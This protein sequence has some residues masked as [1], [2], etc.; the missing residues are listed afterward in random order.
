MLLPNVTRLYLATGPIDGR[1]SFN[2]LGALVQSTLKADPL[3]GHF[4][5]FYNK[6]RNLVKALYWHTN[7]FCLWQKR[8]EKGHFLIPKD[9]EVPL[10]ELTECQ[11]SGL[12]QGINWQKIDRPQELKYTIM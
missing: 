9:L 12:I 3:S 7:G 1:K 8:L 10:F 5:V 11:L 4:F 6:R 2:T